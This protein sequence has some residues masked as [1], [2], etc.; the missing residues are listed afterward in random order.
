MRSTGC[1]VATKNPFGVP[2]VSMCETLGHQPELSSTIT[3]ICSSKNRLNRW[4]GLVYCTIYVQLLSFRTMRDFL[5]LHQP[6][7]GT[8]DAF[9]IES[10]QKES[11]Q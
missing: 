10:D 5:A 2:N 8:W 3:M 11:P 9:I 1:E 4:V 7:V 6:T